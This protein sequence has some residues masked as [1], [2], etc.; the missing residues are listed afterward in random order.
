MI[1]VQLKYRGHLRNISENMLI[2]AVNDENGESNK[3]K[4][5][6]TILYLHGITICI[7]WNENLIQF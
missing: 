6:V 4:N 1:L 7:P 5:Q 2:G 3:V